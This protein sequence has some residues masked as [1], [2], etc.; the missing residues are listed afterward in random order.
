MVSPIYSW[1]F[2]TSQTTL[3]IPPP[4]IDW[5]AVAAE[6]GYNKGDT[7]RTRFGQVKRSLGWKSRSEKGGSAAAKSATPTKVTKAKANGTPRARKPKAKKK[8]EQVKSEAA[9]SEDMDAEDATN[10]HEENEE[11]LKVEEDEE[12]GFASAD[13]EHVWG[14]LWRNLPTSVVGRHRREVWTSFPKLSREVA[15]IESRMLSS[16]FCI[17]CKFHTFLAHFL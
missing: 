9:V 6:A 8:E 4:Q 2:P 17:S 3:T 1:I 7:A 15:Q 12:N 13:E 11:I 5:D 16:C 14:V 10:G